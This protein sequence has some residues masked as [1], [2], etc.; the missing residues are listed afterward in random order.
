MLQQLTAGVSPEQLAQAHKALAALR[1]D[2]PASAEAFD[3]LVGFS[4]RVESIFGAIKKDAWR[5][6]AALSQEDH[7]RAIQRVLADVKEFCDFVIDDAA[8]SAVAVEEARA[9]LESSALLARLSKSFE[10]DGKDLGEC[11]SDL[12]DELMQELRNTLEKILGSR[13]ELD[14]SPRE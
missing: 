5:Q 10:S 9:A 3:N 11:R 12:T 14:L 7:D 8:L 1:E 4:S 6:D 13:L 2:L